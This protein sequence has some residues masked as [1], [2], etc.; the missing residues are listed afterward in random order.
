MKRLQTNNNDARI[1]APSQPEKNDQS[2]TRGVIFNTKQR[3]ITARLL[4]WFLAISLIPCAILTTITARIATQSL[5]S[6]ARNNLIQIA[7]TKAN[8]LEAYAT[9]RVQDGT[10]LSRAPAV[11]NAVR[12][13]TAAAFQI[14]DTKNQ[15]A[16][17]A[18]SI[19]AP[20]AA[21]GFLM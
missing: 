2:Q 8:E 17:S 18:D 4:F 20:L 15:Q 16:A 12:E 6:S 14:A 5:E 1:S 7:A 3:T 10:V 13:L 19:R 11:I 21:E 9:E